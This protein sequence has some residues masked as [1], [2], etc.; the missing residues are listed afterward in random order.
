MLTRLGTWATFHLVHDGHRLQVSHVGE[1]DGPLPYRAAEEG[2]RLLQ[3][4]LQ[5][6]RCVPQHHRRSAALQQGVPRNPQRR[7]CP[8]PQGCVHRWQAPDE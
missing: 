7:W 6:E 8:V 1:A 5:G 3:G 4:V 2:S